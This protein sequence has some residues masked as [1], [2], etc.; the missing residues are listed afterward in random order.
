MSVHCASVC[1]NLGMSEL[2]E[3][4]STPTP[5]AEFDAQD[6]ALRALLSGICGH[7]EADL[8]ALYDATA[9]RLYALALRITGEAP[10]AE[11]VLMDVY[12]QVWR[13]A[14]RYDP[15][16][17]KV[18]PWLCTICRS[19]ALDY[20]RSRE[21][22]AGSAE[23][24][25]HLEAAE[26]NEGDPLDVMVGLE[27]GSLLHAALQKLDVAQ[28]QLVALAFFRDMSQQEIAKCTGMPLGT[29]KTILRRSIQQLRRQLLNN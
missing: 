7:D 20:L 23:L 8:A 6:A 21:Q 24:K 26:S 16:R 18:M 11:E 5:E 25:A 19:R 29:V 17:G 4:A 27:R 15:A 13:Q 3:P 9:S 10:G 22:H 2:S 1:Y 12:H 28:R 14:G